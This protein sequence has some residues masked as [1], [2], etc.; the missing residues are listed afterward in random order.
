MG[1]FDKLFGKRGTSA[2]APPVPTPATNKPLADP[3]VNQLIC[4]MFQAH[5]ANAD[6]AGAWVIV[7]RGKLKCQAVHFSHQQRPNSFH[8]QMDVIVIIE[9]NRVIVESFAG[10][11]T[12]LQ[13]ALTEAASNFSITVF[14]AILSALLDIPCDHADRET[15]NINGTSR[16]ITMGML[17]MRGEMPREDWPEAFQAIENHVSLSNLS[18][19]LHWVRYFYC[20]IPGQ[21][22]VYEVLLDN[23][24]WMPLQTQAAQIPW[25]K[26]DDF[27]TVRLFFIVQDC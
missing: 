3:A 19:G 15:W 6:V 24:T 25:P 14:H 1:L 22:P 18:P 2:A 26:S 8:L 12:D 17:G 5:G 10:I 16:Q 7:E 20:H 4:E 9:K 13:S 21:A 11:G 23:E 27:Y